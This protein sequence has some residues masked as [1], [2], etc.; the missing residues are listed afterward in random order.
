MQQLERTRP[1]ET[2]DENESRPCPILVHVAPEDAASLQVVRERVC[3]HL[4]DDCLAW[5]KDDEVTPW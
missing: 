3:E 5:L 2:E 4:K 1:A